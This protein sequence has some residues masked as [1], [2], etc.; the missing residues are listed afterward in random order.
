MESTAGRKIVAVEDL[1]LETMGV[2]TNFKFFPEALEFLRFPSVL[3]PLYGLTVESGWK[4]ICH[5]HFI[6][7]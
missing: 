7:Y 3:E 1:G 6:T 5:D 2:S 4:W